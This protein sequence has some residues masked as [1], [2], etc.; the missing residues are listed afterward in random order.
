MQ[1]MGLDTQKCL[2][3]YTTREAAFEHI[4]P[5]RKFRLSTYGEMRDPLENKDLHLP[6]G[7]FEGGGD[8]KNKEQAYATFMR[9]T[10]EIRRRAHLLAFTVD[11]DVYAYSPHA[12]SFAAGWSRARMWEHYAEQHAGVY[13]VF[14]K[15]TLTLTLENDLEQQLGTRPFSGDVNYTET[16]S[17]RAPFLDLTSPPDDIE[18]FVPE[19]IEQNHHLLFFEKALDWQTEHEFRFVTTAPTD[20]ELYADYGDSLV[21]IVVGEKFPEWQRPAVLEAG[22]SA[23]VEPQILNWEM[24]QPIPIPLRLNE[25]PTAP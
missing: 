6:A 17:D 2:F 8:E 15:Q 23:G 14:D 4:L 5:A 16:G 13:L 10:A 9:A 19:F 11:A 7:W 3:H 25:S 12:S 18:A 1:A 24:R 20:D 21:G 22:R